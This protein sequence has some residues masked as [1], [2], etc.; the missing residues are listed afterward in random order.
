MSRPPQRV[1]Q[2]RSACATAAWARAHTR[3]YAQNGGLQLPGSAGEATQAW[4][5]R[6][7]A[8]WVNWRRSVS[9]QTKR[10]F[11]RE[12][13]ARAERRVMPG[14]QD[15]FEGLTSQVRVSDRRGVVFECAHDLAVTL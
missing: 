8:G 7:E 3:S 14:H 10:Y 2:T 6:L 9:W 1:T 5:A 15:V 12:Y 11:S 13:A 4:L